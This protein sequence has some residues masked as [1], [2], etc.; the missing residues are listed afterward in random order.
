MKENFLHFVSPVACSIYVNSKHLGTIDNKNVFELDILTKTNEILVTYEPICG[1]EKYIPYSV[2]VSTSHTP[3]C[4]S[5]YANI[6]PF[7]N[8]NYDIILKPFLYHG[9]EN[10]RVLINQSIDKYF[11]SILSSDNTYVTIYSGASIVFR[12][13]IPPLKKA[14]VEY[15]NSI[16]IIRGVIDE[17]TYYL[18]LIDSNNLS[19]L[20][21]DISH[22]IN[23]TSDEIESLKYI[24][25]LPQHAEV[26]KIQLKSKTKEIFYVYKN[27]KPRDTIC[28]YLIPKAF[29]DGLKVNDE[30]L[31][32][33][34]LSN[35]LSNSPLGKFKSYFG[36]IKAVYFNRHSSTPNVNYTILSD[37]YKNYDFIL[38][39][40][41]ITEI[42]EKNN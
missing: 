10:S 20:H 42:E 8:N 26:C 15:T 22:S 23:I 19:I 3:S 32:K 31:C 33:S 5:E 27:G 28:K 14:T 1:K 13:N 16:I 40:N 2:Y 24:D 36:N 21:S 18:M 11:V 37:E 35:T 7:P 4:E 38:E 39:N 29:L 6:I 30:K 41:K 34:L 9:I 17:N 12:D 25:N